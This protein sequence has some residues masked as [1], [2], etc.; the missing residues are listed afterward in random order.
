MQKDYR[1]SSHLSHKAWNIHTLLIKSTFFGLN[2]L[3]LLSFL[4]LSYQL[5]CWFRVSFQLSS[6]QLFERNLCLWCH[7]LALSSLFTDWLK[8]HVTFLFNSTHTL[9]RL[10]CLVIQHLDVSG[11][12]FNIHPRAAVTNKLCSRPADRLTF[13]L[14]NPTLFSR[15][16]GKLVGFLALLF[17]EF[18]R[19][20]A[21]WSSSVFKILSAIFQ[22]FFALKSATQ[23]LFARSRYSK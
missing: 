14:K 11:H 20:T 7:V 3:L 2:L 6:Q 9:V 17:K 15:K 8:C 12:L 18:C 10:L 19:F 1:Q 22:R 21:S 4:F 16:V 23:L 5:D 13:Y